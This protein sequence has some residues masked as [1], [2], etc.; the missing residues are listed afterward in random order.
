MVLAS[1][2]FAWGFG[3][4]S[5]IC[6]G[7][8]RGNVVIGADTTCEVDSIGG[9][10]NLLIWCVNPNNPGN[11]SPPKVLEQPITF[12]ASEPN[13]DGAENTRNRGRINH[14]IHVNTE[15]QLLAQHPNICNPRNSQGNW[16]PVKVLIGG[17]FA[18]T[19][20]TPA[21]GNVGEQ[22]DSYECGTEGPLFNDPDYT[23]AQFISDVTDLLQQYGPDVNLSDHAPFDTLEY[24]CIEL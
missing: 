13:V 3:P 14:T 19:V 16:Y 22:V 15:D 2:A 11:I 18:A 23:V 4:S 1:Q 6:D 10:L 24:N 5:I 17:Q 12:S 9:T 7:F 20:S 21:K 8:W